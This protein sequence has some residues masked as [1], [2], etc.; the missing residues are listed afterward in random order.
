MDLA[1]AYALPARGS[2]LGG[3]DGAAPPHRLHPRN[4]ETS[5]RNRTRRAVRRSRQKSPLFRAGRGF[6]QVDLRAPFMHGAETDEAVD[7]SG[8]PS[9]SCSPSRR[10]TSSMRSSPRRRRSSLRRRHRSLRHRRRRPPVKRHHRPAMPAPRPARSAMTTVRRTSRAPRTGRSTIPGRLP[11]TLGCESCH[12]PGQAHVDDDA[13]GHIRRF[14]TIKPA[15]VNATCLSCHNRGAHAGWEGSTHEARN[16]SCTTCHSVHKPASP[17]HQLAKATETATCATCHRLQVAKTERAVAHMPVREGKMSCSSCHN[18]HGSIANVKALKVGNSV[19]E[20]CTSCHAEMRGPDLV[21]TRARARELH[22]LPRPA[23]VVERPD[24]GRAHADAVSALSRRDA[25]SGVGVRQQR[26]HREQEQPDV[27]AIVRELPLERSRVQ[28]PVGPVLH[29]VAGEPDAPVSY[30]TEEPADRDGGDR[31]AVGAG[32]RRRRLPDAPK[33]AAPAGAQAPAAPPAAAPPAQQTPPPAPAGPLADTS[34]SLFARARQH[35]AARR[36]PEQHV[37]RPGALA[38]LPGSSRRPAVHRRAA[39]AGDAR[40]EGLGRRRQRR[41]ARSAL[42]RGP[43]NG[44]AASRSTDSG[45]RSRSSTASTRERPTRPTTDGVLVLDDAVQQSIQNKT[46]TLSA[47]VPI[48]P[49]IRPARES[50]HRHLW[51]H[52][53]AD[54]ALRRHGRLQDH[55]AL[56]RAALGR[57]LRVQQRRRGGASV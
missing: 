5:P 45:T 21:G 9:V 12:G 30:A 11:A 2:H 57:E 14:G 49:A 10:V 54:A 15:E 8:S 56:R 22:D 33:T 7:L 25:P 50:R 16:L 18:P 27:R 20:S 51:H 4:F 31:R 29:A 48:A 46:A 13:K 39:A 42:L 44:S 41:L 34:T 53:H 6:P 17:Q 35:A 38:A 26:H 47:Y 37:G 52:G 36:P 32:A 40:V 23:R 1:G 24:A 28:S 43:T 3:T 55:E 19:D